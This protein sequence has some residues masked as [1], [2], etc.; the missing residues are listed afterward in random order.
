MIFF[1]MLSK[2]NVFFQAVD[3]LVPSP[4]AIWSNEAT[5][6]TEPSGALARLKAAREMHGN[7]AMQE[8]LQCCAEVPSF[9]KG[10]SDSNVL[11]M[12]GI[13]G[14][15]KITGFLGFFLCGLDI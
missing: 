14:P 1:P 15:L 13:I 10:R 4:P 9:Q 7:D 6:G 5:N 12:D 3:L 2:S 8:A 11:Q